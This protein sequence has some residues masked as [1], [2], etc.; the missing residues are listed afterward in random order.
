MLNIEL[1]DITKNSITL[2]SISLY[3][4]GEVYGRVSGTLAP[5]DPEDPKGNFKAS[6]GYYF[7]TSDNK[8]FNV[9]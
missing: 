3:H 7:K 4:V 9:K 5:P 6:N 2:H 8:N 1:N